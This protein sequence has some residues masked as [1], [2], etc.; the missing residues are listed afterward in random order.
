MVARPGINGT[1]PPVPVGVADEQELGVPK[2]SSAEP[3]GM[4]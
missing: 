1:P 3:I 2:H 4:T